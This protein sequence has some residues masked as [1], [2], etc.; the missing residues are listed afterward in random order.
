MPAFG[1]NL[2]GQI[3][4]GWEVL[5]LIN[6]I[7]E[8]LRP[9]FKLDNNSWCYGFF[10]IMVVI[11]TIVV[12][13]VLHKAFD[14]KEMQQQYILIERKRSVLLNCDK[15]LQQRKIKFRNATIIMQT[16]NLKIKI[17][18]WGE[19]LVEKETAMLWVLAN[20]KQRDFKRGSLQERK[21]NYAIK[22]LNTQFTTN[23]S[24]W[25][26]LSNINSCR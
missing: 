9:L 6:C 15:L 14:M 26:M 18:L 3:R 19:L 22:L 23:H 7:L 12:M 4:M 1:Y 10:L 21:G 5:G 13:L 2:S 20:D 25:W 8:W 24:C 17:F 16:N 11:L